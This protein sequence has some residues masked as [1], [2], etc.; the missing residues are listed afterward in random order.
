MDFIRLTIPY[1]LKLGPFGECSN[2]LE[3]WLVKIEFFPICAFLQIYEKG[4]LN[5]DTYM[6][7]IWTFLSKYLID[8]PNIASILQIL[9]PHL[10]LIV[11]L[12]H[13]RRRLPSLIVG[14]IFWFYPFVY[15]SYLQTLLPFKFSYSSTLCRQVFLSIF[16]FFSSRLSALVPCWAIQIGI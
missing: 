2:P 6:W 15:I 3:S 8:S 5:Y 11:C 13:L 7:N 16:P 4:T 10:S 14:F 12:L 1:I 9:R